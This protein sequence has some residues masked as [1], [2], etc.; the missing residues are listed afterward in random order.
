MK[1]FL[2]LALL[3]LLLG[4][5]IQ[6]LF[7]QSLAEK[8]GQ[9]VM[10]GYINGD[11][12]MD[13]LI[14]D[15]TERNLGGVIHFGYNISSRQQITDR[16][17]DL[18]SMASTKLF[19]ATDQEGGRVARLNANNGFED[20]MTAAFTG[21]VLNSVER[22]RTQAEKMAGWFDEIGM[23][24]NL[25]P[26]VDVN[27]NSS[28][29]A[30]GA[31]QRSYSSDP[32]KVADH[33]RAF[34]DAFSEKKVATAL[35]HFP[36]H[37]SAMADSHFGFTDVTNT[38]TEMELAPY[39]I[40]IQ[41]KQ[42]DMIMTGHLFNENLDPDY[43]A[44]ISQNTLHSL[45]FDSLGYTGIVISDEMFMRALRDNFTFDEAIVLAI[46][47]GTDI[48][49]FNN[50]QC[51][52]NAP[53]GDQT[54]GSLVRYVINLVEQKVAEGE[55]Q[56]ERI[57]ASYQKVLDLKETKFTTDIRNQELPISTTL[58]QNYPNPFNPTTTIQ[59]DMPVSGYAKIVVYDM[60]GR[61]IQQLAEGNFNAGTHRV[62]LDASN[63]A[64][65][66]Y[67][68]TLRTEAGIQTRNMTLIK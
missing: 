30:I 53:C 14:T 42:P 46:N 12:A 33:A 61:I 56:Q 41:E 34:I 17:A 27:V 64:S 51:T 20:T 57:D 23:N 58:H 66:V 60:M 47:A 68:Y 65:G 26:V 3:V 15:I 22:T 45:L 21:I 7:A 19:L 44:S 4:T 67:I 31:L 1:N 55:I 5:S 25:G 18:Q 28:S 8:V 36:G 11:A 13:T 32:I 9:M 62:N 49:L 38:W 54:S 39:S 48:L 24:V 63:M 2:R 35:K 10:V 6:P 59:F 43:P 37:G 52:V 29:P 40:L 50:N 16:N